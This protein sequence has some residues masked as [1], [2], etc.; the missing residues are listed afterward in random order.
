MNEYRWFFLKLV[1]FVV[2]YV[3]VFTVAQCRAAVSTSLQMIVFLVVQLLKQT[4]FEVF[5]V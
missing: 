4:V 3:D 5:T 1:V 2:S